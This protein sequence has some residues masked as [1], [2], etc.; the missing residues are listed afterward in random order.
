MEQASL[1]KAADDMIGK[2][3]A[4]WRPSDG[5]AGRRSSS[6][7]ADEEWDDD[8]WD[9]GPK[10]TAAL[11]A[12]IE[13]TQAANEALKPPLV[14]QTTQKRIDMQAAAQREAAGARELSEEEEKQMREARLEGLRRALEELAQK[15]RVQE[16]HVEA[17]K[18]KQR[19]WLA[20]LADIEG[21]VD[22]T[23]PIFPVGDSVLEPFWPQGLG[24]NRGFHSALDAVWA[25]QVMRE[26]GLDAA[27]LERNF[28]Y[29]LMLQGPWVPAL[30][31]PSKAWCGDPVSRYSDGAILRTKSNY[32]SLQSKR[33]F[34]GGGA[35]PP[36]IEAMELKAER[37]AGGVSVWN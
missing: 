19:D 24:S 26:R 37:G 1:D 3:A 25:V 9:D 15:T 20:K 23:V 31:K 14:G 11:Q 8:E 32:T 2:A 18:E 10:D 12:A 5:M 7:V 13:A 33:L 28:W 21:S 27:L 34:R 6:G 16:A 4:L 36:R 22:C 30:L 17:C 35:T 29:D